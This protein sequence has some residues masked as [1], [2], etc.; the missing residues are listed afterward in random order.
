MVQHRRML[1][2]ERLLL[3]RLRDDDCDTLVAMGQDPRVMEFFPALLTRDETLALRDRV[4]A[5]FDQYGYGHWSLE[6]RDSGEFIGLCGLGHPDFRSE[7]EIGWRLKPSAWHQG[8]ATE[9]ARATMQYAFTEL[10]L[11]E[12]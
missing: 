5:H 3:R 12:V 9:A 8:F 4:N 7:V 2:T 11:P 6:R 10:A 1:Q